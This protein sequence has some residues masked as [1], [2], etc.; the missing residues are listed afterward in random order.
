MPRAGARG[1]SAG[2]W[3]GGRMIC[4]CGCGRQFEAGRPNQ[5]YYDAECRLRAKKQRSQ[6]IRVNRT[7]HGHIKSLRAAQES[8]LRW[9]NPIRSPL[10][11]TPRRRMQHEPLL[12]TPEVAEFLGVSEWQVN[13]WRMRGGRSGPRF[14][15]IGRLVRYFPADVLAW[16]RE[17]R[18]DRGIHG[19]SK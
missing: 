18:S 6:V 7:E 17:H 14:V 15:R 11:A 16:L 19:E 12:T 8:P 13:A 2:A 10:G 5:I 4:A 1:A 3:K 9:G